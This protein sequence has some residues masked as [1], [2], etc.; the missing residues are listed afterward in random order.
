MKLTNACIIVSLTHSCKVLSY[1]Y[2][3]YMQTVA[4]MLISTLKRLN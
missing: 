3:H 1:H 4:E 2:D